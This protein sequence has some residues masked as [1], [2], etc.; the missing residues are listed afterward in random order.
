MK[1]SL[2]LVI[3]TVSAYSHAAL[4][5]GKQRTYEIQYRLQDQGRTLVRL[6]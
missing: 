1:R 2:A 4:R 3:A 5:A 6:R